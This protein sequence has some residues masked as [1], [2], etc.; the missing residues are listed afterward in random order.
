M[1]RHIISAVL[2]LG[3]VL[4]CISMLGSLDEFRFPGDHQGYRPEQPIA[5]SHRVHAGDLTID[6]LYCH[7]GAERSRT[8]GIPSANMCMNCHKFVTATLGAVREE[9]RVAGEEKREPVMIVSA[10]LQK[11]YDALGLDET[12]NPD[13]TK[14]QQ[15]IE[16]VRVHAIPDFV[17][18]DHRPHIAAKVSCQNCHG[19]VERMDRVRQFSTLG[20]GWCVDCHRK[21]SEIIH[22]GEPVGSLLDCTTCHY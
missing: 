17:A 14:T 11:L 2:V 12:L 16:W 21:T 5:F 18:F 8:A 10:E 1:K 9:E 7:P 15:P 20:M 6:C 3:I 19:P 22:P 13:P 4:V